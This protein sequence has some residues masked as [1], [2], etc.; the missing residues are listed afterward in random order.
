MSEAR[1]SLLA[2]QQQLLC[3][4]KPGPAVGPNTGQLSWT[5]PAMCLAWNTRLL[6][7]NEKDGKTLEEP[8]MDH[9]KDLMWSADTND[10]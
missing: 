4:R 9:N 1:L 3:S 8:H 7:K 2:L 5:L 6:A 10:T